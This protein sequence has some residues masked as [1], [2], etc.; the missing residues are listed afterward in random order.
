MPSPAARLC[1]L[2][3]LLAVAAC[4]T[5]PEPE[6]PPRREQMVALTTAHELIRFN[7]GQPRRVLERKALS[8]LAPGDEIVG[9]DYRVARGVLYALSRQGRLY[10]VDSSS[11][12]LTPVGQSPAVPN[13]P[14][15]AV[16]FDFNPAADRIRVVAGSLNLRLHPDTGAA[17]DGDAARDGVQPDAALAYAAGDVNHGRAADI[18]AA[19]YT[20]NKTDDKLTTN[21]ALDR[22]H[23]TLVL[24]GSRE[25][26]QPVVSPNSGRL[27][28]V[29]SLGLGRFADA[30]F[31]IADVNGAALAAIRTDGAP[32]RLYEIDLASGRARLIGTVADGAPLRGLAIEP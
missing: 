21:Y 15:A 19:A 12:R 28:T 31:D 14:A 24:Q 2:L 27:T 22:A 4:A 11:G 3:P 25:G 23:G 5:A 20:Y 16:G 10:T 30:A 13:L 26:T 6:G 32:T 8:G 18:V 9:I 1:R 7:A 29:G 17:V